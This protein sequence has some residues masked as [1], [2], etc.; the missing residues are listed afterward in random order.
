MTHV[1]LYRGPSTADCGPLRQHGSMIPYLYGY[2]YQAQLYPEPTETILD[3]IK[4]VLTFSGDD[5][6]VCEVHH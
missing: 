3:S 2:Q 6:D 5:H 1:P 4:P